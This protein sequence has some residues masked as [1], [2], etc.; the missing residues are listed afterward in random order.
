MTNEPN[1][2]WRVE[3]AVSAHIE[4]HLEDLLDDLIEAA[5]R[6]LLAHTA[7]RER[8]LREA[9]RRAKGGSDE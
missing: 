3:D 1:T 5:E 9:I 4:E 2:G 7:Q 8:A 6:Y